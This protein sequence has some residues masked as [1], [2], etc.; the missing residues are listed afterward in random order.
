MI[1]VRTKAR[2]LIVDDSLMMRAFFGSIFDRAPGIEVVGT[3]ASAE[4]ARRM[5]VQ[6]RPN[7]M[8]L[9]VEMP[10][11]NG[12]EFLEEVMHDRPMPVI[13]LSSLTQKGAETSFQALERGALDCFPKPTSDNREE[14]AQRLCALVIAAANGSARSAR[15]AKD[16]PVRAPGSHH[17]APVF[18]WNGRIVVMGASTGGVDALL[19]L[20]P[21]L[22]ADCPPT[23][24]SLQIDSDF[25]APLMQRL[26]ARCHA[27]V[28][29]AED[30]RPLKR[31][32]IQ[33]AC[34]PATHAVID[35]W[36]DPSVKLLRSDPV[37]GARPSASL[38]FAT[39]AKTAGTHAI[40]AILTGIGTDGVAGMKA[41]RASGA[42][43]I[44]QDALTCL[45]DQ[46]PAAA[47]AAGA[48]ELDLPIEAVAP[49]SL[50]ACRRAADAA[51]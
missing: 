42:L 35:R 37:N 19:Q 28:V 11:T 40:G 29:L 23:V 38:L 14:F 9:D 45:V 6:H 27:K 36:P 18:N 16:A 30:G 20:L 32:E 24:I 21:G 17:H 7:V 47:R 4:E 48:I 25:V 34:D 13:M 43:T 22:P 3:A 2:V 51:A 50:D 10:G 39:A 44:S 41:L 33:I 46:A 8:T 26:K 31:G 1:P 12:L 5:I 49:A 15:Y